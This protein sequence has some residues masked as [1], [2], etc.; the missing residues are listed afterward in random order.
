MIVLAIIV[1]FALGA[2]AA[3]LLARSRAQV[4]VARL[5]AALEHQRE[6]AGDVATRFKALSAETLERTVEL[7]RGQFEQYRDSAAQELQ[8]RHESF[9]QLVK[10]I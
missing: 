10:P 5:E 1:G 9:E 7:A 4:E 8:R 3:W 2:A 6:L